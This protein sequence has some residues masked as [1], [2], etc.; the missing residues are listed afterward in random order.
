[1]NINSSYDIT[2]EIKYDDGLKKYFAEVKGKYYEIKFEQEEITVATEESDLSIINREPNVIITADN[3]LVKWNIGENGHIQLNAENTPGNTVITIKEENSNVGATC[4]VTI[5]SKVVGLTI[6]Q[7]EAKIEKEDVLN[8]T[9]VVTPSNTTDEITWSSRD[10]EIAIVENGKVT[11]REWGNTVITVACGDKTATCN[12]M[13]TYEGL[14][15]VWINKTGENRTIDGKAASSNNPTI[16][17]GFCAVNANNVN[18]NK[19]NGTL[20]DISGGLV[21]KNATDKNEFVWIPCSIDGAGGSIKYDRYAFTRSDWEFKQTKIGTDVVTNSEKIQVTYG[22]G[23]F[24]YTEA[25]PSDEKTSITKYGGYYIGRYECRSKCRKKNIGKYRSFSNTN[26]KHIW[27]SSSTKK[28][29]D[30]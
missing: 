23:T 4:N 15:V 28:Q 16:P 13:V 2:Y 1:M 8:L 20:S 22:N 29:G 7:N 17:A 21:I 27:K 3:N 11:P 14:E 26:R 12:L 9:A 24:Y 6:S 30:I 25:M 18:W 19:E 5:V 10:E